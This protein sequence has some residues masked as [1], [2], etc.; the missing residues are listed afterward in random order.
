MAPRFTMGTTETPGLVSLQVE[1]VKS[2]SK[3]GTMVP[4][5]II[6]RQGL[7]KDR[8]RPT[9]LIGYGAYRRLHSQ[10]EPTG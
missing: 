3:D 7:T 1:H 4:L 9:L 8:R 10:D 5:T 6:S 2:R